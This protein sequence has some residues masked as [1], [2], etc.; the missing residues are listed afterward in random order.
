MSI[1]DSTRLT[2][3]D[4]RA[5][6]NDDYRKRFAA[7]HVIADSGCWLWT[8]GKRGG[9]YGGFN[10]G[11][12]SIQRNMAAHRVSWL[13]HKG[14]L[15]PG[16][17][18]CHR[19]DNPLCVN[20]DHLFLGTGFDNMKDCAAKGRII[21]GGSGN[22]THCKR[23]HEFTAENTYRDHD[24]HRRCNTCIKGYYQ[25]QKAERALLRISPKGSYLNTN[26]PE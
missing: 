18:V 5:L 13:I 26:Y 21:P 15:P 4:I 7:K 1:T 9:G 8:A 19:C 11:P 25:E 6:L 12:K 16:L 23:G 24:G 2:D 10:V 22:K 14:E 20:P 3:A 17:Q